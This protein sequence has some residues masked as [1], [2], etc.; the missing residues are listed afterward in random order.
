MLRDCYIIEPEVCR[1]R[2]GL[3]FESFNK[4]ELETLLGSALNFVQDNHSVSKKGVLRGLHFQQGAHA[5]AKLV[6]VVHGEVIDV[7]LDLRKN[8]SSYGQHYKVRLSAV[9]RKMLF[10]PRGMAHGFL[11]IVH[12][13]IFLYKSDNYYHKESEG[14]ILFNDPDLA[15]DWE[16]PERELILSDKDSQWPRFKQ[17]AE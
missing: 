4:D 11:S 8:S 6:R 3:F 9:N 17:W 10:I 2:R 14:G 16:Y 5:Q 7:V 15:I 13:T 1:D 12:D